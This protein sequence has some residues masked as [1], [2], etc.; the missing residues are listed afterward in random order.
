MCS[1]GMPRVLAPPSHRH[2]ERSKPT[3]CLSRFAPAKRSACAERNLSTRCIK[4]VV[5]S[6]SR[7]VHRGQ[8]SH[9][10]IHPAEAKTWPGTHSHHRRPPGD[11]QGAQ[12]LYRI[13]SSIS[14][15]SLNRLPPNSAALAESDAPPLATTNNSSPSASPQNS[16]ASFAAWPPDNPSPTK[17]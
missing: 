3:P 8:N 15:T 14:R 12:S 16:S 2:F 6:A 11:A 5:D 13:A 4:A 7:V 9:R 10:G 17:L 1:L